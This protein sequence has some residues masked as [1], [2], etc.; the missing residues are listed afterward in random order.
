MRELIFR[1]WDTEEKEWTK[2]FYVQC[3]G[4]VVKCGGW[5]ELDYEDLDGQYE[6]VQYTGLRDKHRVEI[7]EGDIVRGNA[8][9]DFVIVPMLGGLSLL[10]I[11]YLGQDHN[12]LIAMPTNDVQT[13]SWLNESEVVGNIYENPELLK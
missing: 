11:H 8:P 9:S 3:H 2:A 5:P 6:V 13:A 4:G 10:S 7:Y 12:E 1:A